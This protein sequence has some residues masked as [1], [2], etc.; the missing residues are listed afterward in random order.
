MTIYSDDRGVTLLTSGEGDW[1]T[2]DVETDEPIDF[3]GLISSHLSEGEVAVLVTAGW[4]RQRYVFG[5][6]M[7]VNQDGE[8]VSVNTG[9]IYEL[10]RAKFGVRPSEATC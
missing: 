3:L 2:V 1:P 9:D 4:E 10:A 6:A 5:E 7:A 8:V